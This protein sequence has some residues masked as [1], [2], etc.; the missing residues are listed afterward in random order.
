M[1]QWHAKPNPKVSLCSFNSSKYEIIQLRVQWTQKAMQPPR[2]GEDAFWRVAKLFANLQA[3]P[4]NAWFSQCYAGN[5]HAKKHHSHCMVC[6]KVHFWLYLIYTENTTE[7][8]K[9]TASVEMRGVFYKQW[10]QTT[11]VRTGQIFQVSPKTLKA[12]LQDLTS[13]QEE[14]NT[15]LVLEILRQIFGNTYFTN[16][17]LKG[18][19]TILIF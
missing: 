9:H 6:H 16:A 13:P 1:C 2:D 3:T 19:A 11:W 15:R 5:W 7:G 12:R 18:T 14:V 17:N 8:N 4:D 10:G